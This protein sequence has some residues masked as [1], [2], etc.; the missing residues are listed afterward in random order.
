MG[1]KAP[2][3][4]GH[5]VPQRE[6]FLCASVYFEF[7]KAELDWPEKHVLNQVADG[8]VLMAAWKTQVACSCIGYA[9]IRGTHDHNVKLSADR[10]NQVKDR[11]TTMAG[12]VRF[13]A[14]TL[15][16]GTMFAGSKP[17]QYEA[18]RRVDVKITTP[19]ARDGIGFE[20]DDS[21]EAMIFTKDLEKAEI[22]NGGKV[23]AWTELELRL[24][25]EEHDEAVRYGW[26]RAEEVSFVIDRMKTA[27]FI[28]LSR[29]HAAAC[30]SVTYKAQ[31]GGRHRVTVRITDPQKASLLFPEM[32]VEG[33]AHTALSKE[34][35]TR[36]CGGRRSISERIRVR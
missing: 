35:Y 17:D 5:P 29:R 15:G 32:T 28:D 8:L 9:D 25:K 24:I 26:N 22:A 10:A 30:A 36:L 14:T 21:A 18:D 16:M 34:L 13:S 33:S 31:P 3:F 1:R 2:E 19:V 12:G 23:M 4:Y 11:L 27:A 6:P 20:F 7:D